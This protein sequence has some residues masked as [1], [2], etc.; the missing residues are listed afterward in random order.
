MLADRRASSTIN[1]QGLSSLVELHLTLK[2]YELYFTLRNLSSLKIFHLFSTNINETN[3]K[4]LFDQLQTIEKLFLYGKLYYFNLN[5]LVNL[6]RLILSGSTSDCFNFE[7]LKN[8]PNQLDE[9]AIYIDNIDYKT[10]AKMIDCHDVSKL[11]MLD[12][13]NCDIKILEKKFIHK[14]SNLHTFRMSNC[15]IETIED[16][17]FSNLKERVILDLS[18]NLLKR[19]YKRYFS[20][21]INL[22]NVIMFKNRIEFI[23]KGTF[24]KMK[25]FNLLD[26]S[27]NYIIINDFE[28]YIKSYIKF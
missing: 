22:E 8:L 21:L 26:L 12:I 20:K 27:D 10:L 7:L 6:R 28:P 5:N 2:A 11:L 9:L 1:I 3:T 16:N 4:P 25:N 23:E 17:A 18:E 24:S 19:L 15:K 14:F 13:M